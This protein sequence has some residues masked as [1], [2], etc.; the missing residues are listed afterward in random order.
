MK[1]TL[2]RYTLSTKDTIYFCK[3]IWICQWKSQWNHDSVMQFFSYKKTNNGSMILLYNVQWNHTSI[4][5][6]IFRPPSTTEPWFH[7]TFFFTDNAQGTHDSTAIR[8]TKEKLN[9]MILLCNNFC[10]PLM[11]QNHDSIV[12]CNEG[13]LW[14]LGML[15]GAKNNLVRSNNNPQLLNE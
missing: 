12:L 14:N 9:R 7:Y 11:Q 10:T 1:T 2:C 8:G 4:V 3:L 5:H 6:V 13:Y 15:V